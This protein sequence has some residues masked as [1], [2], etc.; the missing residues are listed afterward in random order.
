[1][2]TGQ[3]WDYVVENVPNLLMAY[4]ETPQKIFNTTIQIPEHKSDITRL[5]AVVNLG[6]C[7]W[8]V[9]RY[10]RNN[11]ERGKPIALLAFLVVCLINISKWP[12]LS[13]RL[14]YFW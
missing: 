4:R 6:T 12:P 11:L 7:I 13:H 2:P 1:M 10:Q 9:D 3:W 14:L 8:L 5:E